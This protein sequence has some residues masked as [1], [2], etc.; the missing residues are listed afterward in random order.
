MKQLPGSPPDLLVWS[1][2][3]EEAFEKL[4][5]MIA[6]PSALRSPNFE[7]KFWL[8]LC[9]VLVKNADLREFLGCPVVRTQRF[10]PTEV[11]WV[12]SQVQELRPLKLCGVAKKILNSLTESGLKSKVLQSYHSSLTYSKW[13]QISK[14]WSIFYQLKSPDWIF[15]YFSFKK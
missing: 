1:L 13:E 14:N 11:A 3:S 12:Q 6:S 9:A 5:L 15:Q 8:V 10:P 7:K 2:E 4:K